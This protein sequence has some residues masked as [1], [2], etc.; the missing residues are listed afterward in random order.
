MIE[1]LDAYAMHG[2][3]EADGHVSAERTLREVFKVL[4]IQK[5]GDGNAVLTGGAIGVRARDGLTVYLR[6]RL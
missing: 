1:P 3:Q 4:L 5:L 6:R 2:M